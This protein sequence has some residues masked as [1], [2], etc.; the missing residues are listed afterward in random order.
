MTFTIYS[1]VKLTSLTDAHIQEALLDTVESLENN[2]TYIPPS[3][4]REWLVIVDY[5]SIKH[6]NE[7]DGWRLGIMRVAS[8]ARKLNLK[9]LEDEGID[10]YI[11]Q[12]F[13]D[14]AD[15]EDYQPYP[16]GYIPRDVQIFTLELL[17]KCR[18]HSKPLDIERLA[19][20]G[21]KKVKDD[22]QRIRL[23]EIH[24]P[25]KPVTV[26]GKLVKKYHRG[27]QTRAVSDVDKNTVDDICDDIVKGEWDAWASQASVFV[28]PKKYQYDIQLDDGRIVK[29]RYGIANGT[30][31]WYGARQAGEEYLIAWVID[32]PLSRLKQYATAVCNPPKDASGGASNPRTS[33]CIVNSVVDEYEQGQTAFAKR[34]KDANENRTEEPEKVIKEH[35]QDPIV[36]YKCR[37]RE[38]PSL[39]KK[40]VGKS[41]VVE[42]YS[43]WSANDY[44][45]IFEEHSASTIKSV[46]KNK[47]FNSKTNLTTFI[48]KDDTTLYDGITMKIAEKAVSDYDEYGNCRPIEICDLVPKGTPL[49]SSNSDEVRMRPVN[50]VKE[51]INTW[52]RFVHLMDEKIGPSLSWTAAP[53]LKD[54]KENDLLP[55]EVYPN[56]DRD[57]KIS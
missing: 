40:I 56:K 45:A 15:V 42:E 35:L 29:V 23:E 26:D 17:E 47:F 9:M 5:E 25:L 34:L 27:F 32:L 3:S 55:I 28:L 22:L 48:N 20:F 51:N 24:E 30:H 1:S 57:V 38:I 33:A 8:A 44:A 49:N 39:V 13:P 14:W 31:R 16:E 19:G 7:Q 37:S 41:G 52:R 36:G 18:K 53:Q 54:E 2:P 6:D 50:K 10:D 21:G 46:G 11:K 4:I 43:R 12:N